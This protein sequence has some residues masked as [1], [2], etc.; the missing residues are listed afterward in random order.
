[1]VHFHK[2]QKI[3]VN[4]NRYKGI[5]I[6]LGDWIKFNTYGVYSQ[7]IFELEYWK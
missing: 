3:D 4:E 6:T 1:M 5:Y 7:G 2:P